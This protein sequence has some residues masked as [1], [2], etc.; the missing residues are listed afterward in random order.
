MFNKKKKELDASEALKVSLKGTELHIN[1]PP[2]VTLERMQRRLE[3]V[4]NFLA[5]PACIAGS[6]KE[7]EF[8]AIKR[9]LELQI[10]LYRGEY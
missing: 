9:R 5:S 7:R 4:K 3:R 2:E 8:D 10:I 6:P 1:P